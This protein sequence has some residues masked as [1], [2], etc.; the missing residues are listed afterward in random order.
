MIVNNI[1]QLV[2][3]VI[4]LKQIIDIN[5]DNSITPMG[6]RKLSK[7]PEFPVQQDITGKKFNW[8]YVLNYVGL[9]IKY[10]QMS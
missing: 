10:M 3:A 1:C 4:I 8:L 9:H 6:K 5:K 7:I 2:K